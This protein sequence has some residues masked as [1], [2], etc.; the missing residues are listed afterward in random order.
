MQHPEI[1]NPGEMYQVLKVFS[2]CFQLSFEFQ[3]KRRVANRRPKTHRECGQNPKLTTDVTPI[4]NPG[5]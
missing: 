4:M 3:F 5:P 2:I 1:P